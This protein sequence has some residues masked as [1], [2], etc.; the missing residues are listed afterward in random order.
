[1]KYKR[2]KSTIS[3]KMSK[4]LTHPYMAETNGLSAA[5]GKKQ[6]SLRN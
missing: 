6:K 2:G 3:S 1:M 4:K 5:K